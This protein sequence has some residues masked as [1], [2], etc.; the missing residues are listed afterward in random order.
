MEYILHRKLKVDLISVG[1]SEVVHHINGNIV[2]NR[3]KNLMLCNDYSEH[4]LIHTDLRK[5][6]VPKRYTKEM[7]I[8]Y[9]EYTSK[10]A[11]NKLGK[12]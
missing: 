5:N 6:I 11:K 1:R 8:E 4:S 3:P 7:Y 12:T 10:L 9:K 2:D